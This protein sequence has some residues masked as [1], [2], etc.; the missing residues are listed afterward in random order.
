M[1]VMKAWYTDDIYLAALGKLIQ[2]ERGFVEDHAGRTLFGITER[3]HP[4]LWEAGPPTLEDAADRYYAEYWLGAGCDRIH[5]PAVAH[6]LF[7]TAVLEG[8]SRAIEHLQ[9]AVNTLSPDRE[10]ITVDGQMGP[11][12]AGAAN[13][14]RNARALVGYQNAHQAERIIDLVRGNPNKFLRYAAGWARRFSEDPFPD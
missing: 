5:H 8:P 6:E 2:A 10:G 9:E 12:T 14:F 11:Q 4:D 13:S 3:D 7:N 1:R